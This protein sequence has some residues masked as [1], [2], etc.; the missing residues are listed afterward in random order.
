[1]AFGS[2]LAEGTHVRLSGQD[3]E[4]G[5]F[6]QRHALLHDQKTEKQHVPLN[7]LVRAGALSSQSSFTVCNS[8]LSE[9]GTLGF[10][11]GYSLVTPSQLI[12][13]EAQFG[14]F[15]NNAQCIIDQFICSGEQKW[16]QRSALTMLLPHGYDGQGPEHSSARIERFLQLC[17]EDPYHM[18]DAEG[19]GLDSATRQHQ[20][21]NIQVI[22]PTV[23]SNYFH[24]LR[25]QI[26]RDFRK[27]LIVFTSKALLRHPAAKSA[28]GEMTEGTRFQRLI[29]EVLHPN[30][31][32][33]LESN[34]SLGLKSYAGN[35]IEPRIPYSSLK[36][37][38]YPTQSSVPLHIE[39]DGFTLLP[40]DEIKTLIFCT[41]QV[42]Y[43]LS[44][45]RALNNFRHIAIVRIE[46]I[47]PFPFWECKAVV[48]FYGKSLEEIV[49]CQEESLN[50]GTWSFIEPRLTTAIQHSNWFK[51]DKVLMLF[52]FNC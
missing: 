10:E 8:S 42:Y 35:N 19:E 24:A 31:L 6:S 26:H 20:D 16:L 29:P 33:P 22:Y 48:D 2:L 50:S 36:D 7:N 17:D 32:K 43:L 49:F 46:Q 41:G 25:R 28:I 47:N 44:K 21:C 34:A 3:V 15:A 51:S 39:S 1:M 27:P 52:F 38:A 11:L 13:W 30:A 12:L 40:P 9:F 4:R 45:A 23:P 14:D 18:P 5:T 37:S